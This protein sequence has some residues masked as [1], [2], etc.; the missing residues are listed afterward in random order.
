MTFLPK[1]ICVCVCMCVCIRHSI[2]LRHLTWF[3]RQIQTRSSL[4][5][6]IHCWVRVRKRAIYFHNTASN[7]PHTVIHWA[8]AWWNPELFDG[9]WISAPIKQWLNVSLYGGN[10]G[11]FSGN[12]WLFSAKE[13]MNEWGDSLRGKTS[14]TK[15]VTDFDFRFS[16]LIEMFVTTIRFL[17]FHL[18]PPN[19]W[20][21]GPSR[22]WN[23]QGSNFGTD[24]SL[25]N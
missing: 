9:L 16:V 20:P 3:C 15:A 14:K 24:C 17:S 1:S 7:F 4:N 25:M 8:T 23:S 11:L 22:G 10:L 18:G 6:L 13:L 12:I 5:L 19:Q 2:H 21:S